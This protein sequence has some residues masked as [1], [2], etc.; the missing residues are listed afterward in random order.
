MTNIVN[1]FSISVLGATFPNPT[2]VK[3]VHVKYNAVMY[4]DLKINY[5]TLKCYDKPH[6]YITFDYKISSTSSMDPLNYHT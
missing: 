4:R 5:N 1:P 6:K 2:L 3:D